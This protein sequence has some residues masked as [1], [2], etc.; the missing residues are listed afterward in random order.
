MSRVLPWTVLAL[1][2]ALVAAPATARSQDVR[3]VAAQR[4]RGAEEQLDVKIQFGAG[5][6]NLAPAPAGTL[7][8]SRFRYDARNFEPVVEYSAGKLHIG[9]ESPGRVSVR[10]SQASELDLALGPDVALALDLQF[11][12]AQADLELGGLNLRRAV[13]ATGASETTLRFSRPNTGQAEYLRLN[14]GAAAFRA[15]G[16]GNANLS[17]L[18]VEGAVGDI[19]LDFSGQWRSDMAASVKVGL[20]SLT[21]NLP[22]GVGVRL[23]REGVLAKIDAH[24]LVRDADGYYYSEDWGSA[25]H[26]LTLRLDAAFG[27]VNVRWVDV[28]LAAP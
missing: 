18:E 28:D 2:A 22:R 7:Y 8:R 1:A 14:A 13:I 11:G 19:V 23:A 6:L 16:L 3:V 4:Q 21:L 20:G 26:K 15:Y 24:G 5:E 27:A 9:L 25:R 17:R 10:R 12:A